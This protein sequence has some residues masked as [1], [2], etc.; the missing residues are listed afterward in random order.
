MPCCP[1]IQLDLDK[2]TD[3]S[4]LDSVTDPGWNS[5]VFRDISGMGFFMRL[6]KVQLVYAQSLLNFGASAWDPLL[7]P[8]STLSPL[9]NQDFPGVSIPWQPAAIPDGTC[10]T[11][12]GRH[13]SCAGA[14]ETWQAGII[15]QI[16]EQQAANNMPPC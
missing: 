10:C 2:L 15:R 1:P 9:Y 11:A 13:V 6:D 16:Q 3:G 7:A 5:I 14:V 12:C 4:W 8:V